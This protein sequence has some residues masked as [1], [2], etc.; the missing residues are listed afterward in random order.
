MRTDTVEIYK[1]KRLLAKRTQWRWRY[2]RSNGKKLA[3]SAESYANLND[4]LGSLATV[5]GVPRT[6]LIDTAV[7]GG[8]V[9]A[10]LVRRADGAAVH[11]IIKQ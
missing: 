11:V 4:L 1:S 5:L 10:L 9:D 2:L 7:T 3:D 6:D 8:R